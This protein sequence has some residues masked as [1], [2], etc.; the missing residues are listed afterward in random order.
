VD[1]L[2]AAMGRPDIERMTPQAAIDTDTAPALI[3]RYFT[4]VHVERYPCDLEIPAAEPVLAYLGSMTE[5]P[6]SPTEEAVSRAAI[7]RR[8]EAE[9]TFK[10]RKDTSLITARRP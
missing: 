1:A 7:T 6:L 2:A 5:Q 9:G 3:A 8:I 4:G 10:V